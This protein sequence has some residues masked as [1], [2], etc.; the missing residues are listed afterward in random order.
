[1]QREKIVSISGLRGFSC[2]IIMLYHYRFILLNNDIGLI[3]YGHYF[4]EVF[5]T[6]SGFLMAFNYRNRILGMN[7]IDFFVKRYLKIMPLYWITEICA[8]AAIILAT[9]LSG[10]KYWRNPIHLLLEFSGFYTGWFGQVEPPVNNPLWTVCSLLLCYVLYYFICR[11]S[12][13]RK[14]VYT[15]LILGLIFTSVVSLNWSVNKEKYYLFIGGEDS[16]RCIISFLMGLLLYELYEKINNQQ[17]KIISYLL[18]VVFVVIII[19]FGSLK[20]VCSIDIEN[21]TMWIVIFLFCPL[22]LYSAIY[23]KIIKEVF[24]GGVL[25]F[26]GKLSM[27]IYMW[28]WVVR[29]YLGSRPFYLNQ[30]T[31]SGWTILVITSITLSALSYYVFMPVIYRVIE[32]TKYAILNNRNTV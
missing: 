18:M 6:I 10:A 30:E 12:K 23:I 17:G 7:F 27:D 24:S 13:S 31:W 1:M 29:I 16:V 26:I 3:N 4:V 20:N 32:K 22:V 28:H 2:L 19:N 15:G 8:Y 5:V 11:V 21:V 9:V 14:S 25:Q